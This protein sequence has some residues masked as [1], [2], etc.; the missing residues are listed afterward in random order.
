MPDRMMR[1]VV[2]HSKIFEPP[3]RAARNGPERNHQA[4]ATRQDRC[5]DPDGHAHSNC[6]ERIRELRQRFVDRRA[7]RSHGACEG[8]R[9]VVLP[10]RRGRSPPLMPPAPREL[11]EV[12][13]GTG[14][15]E[16]EMI[17]GRRPGGQL[18]TKISAVDRGSR[19]STRQLSA[20]RRDNAD[21][22]SRGIDGIDGDRIHR[23]QPG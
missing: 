6:R 2:H 12:D 18:S 16:R 22:A 14:L 11:V 3:G 21:A 13:L 5:G 23:D 8:T 4:I 15:Y 20:A 1:Q 17:V 10:I 7:D 9:M 19:K